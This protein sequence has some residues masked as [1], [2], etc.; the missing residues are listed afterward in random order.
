V[1]A[2]CL[3]DGLF[4][5]AWF[6]ILAWMMMCRFCVGDEILLYEGGVMRLK[7]MRF[8]GADVVVLRFLVSRFAEMI[9][10]SL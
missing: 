6:E 5:E 3:A 2:Q 9:F 4:V 1:A 10:E 8:C 7:G